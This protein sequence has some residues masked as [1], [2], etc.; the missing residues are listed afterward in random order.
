MKVHENI[1]ARQEAIAE[2]NLCTALAALKTLEEV[3]AFLHD[4]CTP[5]EI[6]AMADRWA[7]VPH[8]KREVPY[9]EIHRLTG[10]SVTTIGRV[11]RFLT[12]GHGGYATAS[13][14]LERYRQ[15]PVTTATGI[16]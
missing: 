15:T 6:Q 2:R 8:L 14:R 13:R 9:R 5:T 4:L 7:V 12:S 11:A 3:R 10:V 16:A 1:T